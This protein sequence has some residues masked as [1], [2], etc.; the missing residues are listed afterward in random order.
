MKSTVKV[1]VPTL[2]T[3]TVWTIFSPK[4]VGGGTEVLNDPNDCL[5]SLCANSELIR[6]AKFLYLLIDLN[7]LRI[8]LENPPSPNREGTG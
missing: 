6:P 2:D 1:L 5:E 4:D 3:K 7:F 8:P